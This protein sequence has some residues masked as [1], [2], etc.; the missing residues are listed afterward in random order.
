MQLQRMSEMGKSGQ[1]VAPPRL[2]LQLRVPKT[3]KPEPATSRRS[4][5]R[6]ERTF[7]ALLRVIQQRNVRKA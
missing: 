3:G 2:V 5:K 6:H 7:T 4:A 1:R